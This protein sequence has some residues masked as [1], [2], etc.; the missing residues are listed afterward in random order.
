MIEIGKIWYS[1]NDNTYVIVKELKPD[2]NEDAVWWESLKGYSWERGFHGCH[3]EGGFLSNFK[4]YYMASVC[5]T[6]YGIN[7][8]KRLEVECYGCR[9]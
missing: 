8:C 7:P 1:E 4:Q 5:L 3:H 6:C 9:K 2:G